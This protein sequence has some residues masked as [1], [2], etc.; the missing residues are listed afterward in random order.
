MT[1]I[2]FSPALQVPIKLANPT[3]A[4]ALLSDVSP[5]AGQVSL[6]RR[7]AVMALV[8]S[9]VQL[10]LAMATAGGAVGVASAAPRVVSGVVTPRSPAAGALTASGGAPSVTQHWHRPPRMWPEIGKPMK[11]GGSR[12]MTAPPMARRRNGSTAR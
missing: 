9:A 10:A 3:G 8:G 1:N 7:E 2:V 11:S 5:V 6:V 4:L 12:T